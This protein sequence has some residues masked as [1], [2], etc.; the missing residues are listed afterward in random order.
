MGPILG[1]IYLDPGLCTCGVNM[2]LTALYTNTHIL[3]KC[4]FGAYLL[5]RC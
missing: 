1:P 5:T 2:G 3:D 4:H